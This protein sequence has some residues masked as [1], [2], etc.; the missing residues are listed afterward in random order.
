M[1]IDR[2]SLKNMWINNLAKNLCMRSF[3]TNIQHTFVIIGYN[4]ITRLNGVTSVLVK[5]YQYLV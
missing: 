2:C 3:Y 4:R 5:S 1:H